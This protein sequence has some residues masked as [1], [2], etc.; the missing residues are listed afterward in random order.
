MENDVYCPLL[1]KNIE[2]PICFDISMV[3]DDGAPRWTA[4]E[5]AYIDNFEKICSACPNHRDN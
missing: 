1:G 2:I 4:P 5:E 3:V